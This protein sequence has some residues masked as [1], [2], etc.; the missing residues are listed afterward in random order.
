MPGPI[1]AFEIEGA[2]DAVQH[3]S[4][5][6]VGVTVYPD[7]ASRMR[8][9]SA[10]KRAG[11]PRAARVEWLYAELDGVRAYVKDD[12]AAVHVVVTRRDLYP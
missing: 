7:G 12:G 6:R 1:T 2:D 3:A 5:G 8:R 9:R 11:S 10:I 4:N